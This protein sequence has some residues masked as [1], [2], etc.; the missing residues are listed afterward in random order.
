M[1]CEKCENIETMRNEDITDFDCCKCCGEPLPARDHAPKAAD[2]LS[3][4]KSALEDRGKERDK[5]NGERSMAL[6][7]DIFNAITGKDLTEGEG[8]EFMIALKLARSKQGEFKEDDYIDLA[9]YAALLG[10]CEAA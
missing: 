10:E 7:V 6:A 3:S 8:W 5:P 1:T 4:A 9:G 2:L